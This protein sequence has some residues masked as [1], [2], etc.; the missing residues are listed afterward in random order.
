MRL[1]AISQDSHSSPTI[2]R[3]ALYDLAI[4]KLTGFGLTVIDVDAGLKNLAESAV[5]GSSRALAVVFRLHDAFGRTLPGKLKSL[6][7]PILHLEKELHLLPPEMY[8]SE[9]VRGFEKLYQ[10]ESL[11]RTWNVYYDEALLISDTLLA[12]VEDTLPRRTD[13]TIIDLTKLRC[14]WTHIP[15]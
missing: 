14:V 11:R 2:R 9:R 13:L 3:N 6:D 7:H 4:C 15:N 10:Q 8:Y 1:E 5:M 12:S